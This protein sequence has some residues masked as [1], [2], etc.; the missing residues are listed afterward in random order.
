ME[1]ITLANAG[2]ISTAR[3]GLSPDAKIR[4]VM[5]DSIRLD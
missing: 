4:K 3:N 1:E 5:L 2:D